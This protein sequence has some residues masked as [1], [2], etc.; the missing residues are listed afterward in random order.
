MGD[1]EYVLKR[2]RC[3]AKKRGK[4]KL[5]PLAAFME[6]FIRNDQ[7]RLA[8]SKT[9]VMVYSSSIAA[10]KPHSSKRN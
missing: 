2:A 4:H 7:W 5:K 10:V 9:T 6:N 3:K 1:L 8:Q